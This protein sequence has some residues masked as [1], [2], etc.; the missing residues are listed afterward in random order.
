M[1]FNST[2]TLLTVA[3]LLLTSCVKVN[4]QLQLKLKADYS[5]QDYQLLTTAF[6]PLS[7]EENDTI[8]GQELAFAQHLASSFDF[9]RAI[10]SL[11][12]AL[13]LIPQ[14]N[15]SR[16]QQC[17][18]GILLCYTLAGEHDKARLFFKNSSLPSAPQS[19]PARKELL[20]LL[21]IIYE[22]D[23]HFEK[24]H[25][26][27]LNIMAGHY[28]VLEKKT[29]ISRALA[30]A[31]LQDAI[32]LSENTP[33]SDIPNAIK[34]CYCPNTKSIKTAQTLNAILPGAGY[35]YV[36]QRQSALTS[37]LLNAIFIWSTIELFHH[38]HPA[39]ALFMLSLESGWYFGGILGAGLAAREY[40]E[41]LYTQTTSPLLQQKKYHPIFMLKHTF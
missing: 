32:A 34:R 15:L 26:E 31:K 13:F 22:S 18:F 39:P 8:W 25:H 21:E 33:F 19:F 29:T 1:R 10:T 2:I 36:G 11:K 5:Q 37:L 27:V 9:Y 30:S 24:A 3:S 40:N 35:L 14:S 38:D 41:C 17:E 16:R 23:P 4:P 20:T 7:K 6:N 12:K 28:P